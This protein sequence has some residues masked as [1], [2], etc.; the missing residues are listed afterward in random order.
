MATPM[1]VGD[2]VLKATEPALVPD[3]LFGDWLQTISSFTA[4]SRLILI[5]RALHAK[6]P[7]GPRS[8]SS[9]ISTQAPSRTTSGPTSWTRSGS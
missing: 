7:T 6:T 4:F 2:M 5:L 8:S 3:N 1:Q 9:P